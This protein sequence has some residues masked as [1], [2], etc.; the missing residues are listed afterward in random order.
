M[1]GYKYYINGFPEGKNY[2]FSFGFTWKEIEKLF[3][4]EVIK[5]EQNEFL[6]TWEEI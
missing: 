2:F 3:D 5:K 4:G 1:T 6:I